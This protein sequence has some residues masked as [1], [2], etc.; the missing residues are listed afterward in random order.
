MLI[1]S[2]VSER[3]RR[4]QRRRH[5]RTALAAA[6]VAQ[7]DTVLRGLAQQTAVEQVETRQRVEAELANQ[8]ER[9]ELAG[10]S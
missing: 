10:I 8:R 2:R 3:W 7:W 4:A 5:E 9:R 1:V 6:K